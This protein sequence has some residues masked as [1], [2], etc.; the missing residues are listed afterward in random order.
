VFLPRSD[1]EV[2]AVY[3]QPKPGGF[4]LPS[5]SRIIVGKN[6]AVEV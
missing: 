6:Q 1:S 5:L 3:S 2:Q 4:V